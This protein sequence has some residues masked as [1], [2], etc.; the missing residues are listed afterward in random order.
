VARRC[1]G[2]RVEILC[3]AM[4]CIEASSVRAMKVLRHVVCVAV[5]VLQN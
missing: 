2:K 4:G 5:A 3:V 1:A